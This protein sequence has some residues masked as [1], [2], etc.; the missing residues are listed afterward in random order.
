MTS[1]DADLLILYLDDLVSPAQKVSIETRLATEPALQA[2]LDYLRQIRRMIQNRPRESS[3]L[4][5]NEIESRIQAESQ[6]IWTHLEWAGR[7]LVPFLAAAAVIILAILSNFSGAPQAEATLTAYFQNQE[8]LILS[9]F[10]GL[11]SAFLKPGTTE[12]R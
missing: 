4:I 10:T 11:D 7:R 12:T 5:W 2:E 6:A 1:D 3:P 8:G 9:E